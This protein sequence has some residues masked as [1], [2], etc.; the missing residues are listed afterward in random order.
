[1]ANKPDIMMS[2]LGGL[3]SI[4][5]NDSLSMWS[6]EVTQKLKKLYLHDHQTWQ[7]DSMQQ[8]AP[9]HKVT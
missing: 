8:G 9:T 7:S 5:S 1:M 4:Y 6:W 2:Y 3:L